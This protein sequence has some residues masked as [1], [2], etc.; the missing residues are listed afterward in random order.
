MPSRSHVVCLPPYRPNLTPIEEMFS[1]KGRDAFG[2]G[3]DDGC[4][5]RG[6]SIGLAWMT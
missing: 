6:V 3:N 1:K 2:G 5:L 4:S